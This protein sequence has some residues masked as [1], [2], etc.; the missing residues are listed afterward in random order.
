[1][2][3]AATCHADSKGKFDEV[4]EAKGVK[5]LIEPTAVMHV[6]G[7]RMDFLQDSLR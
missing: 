4:V 1:M 5:V 2:F 7:T 3:L 6:I